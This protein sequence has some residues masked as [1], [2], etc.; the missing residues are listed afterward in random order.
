MIMTITNVSGA[1]LTVEHRNCVPATTLAAGGN[2]ALGVS[3]I[4]LR[5]RGDITGFSAAMYLDDL[6]KKGQITCAFA[7][8]ANDL[9]VEDEAN[10]V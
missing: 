5:A 4:D 1:E 8:D 6:V 3:M 7:A 2:V 10:E 9:N